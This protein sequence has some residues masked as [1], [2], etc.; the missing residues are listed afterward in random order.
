MGE[1]PAEWCSICTGSTAITAALNRVLEGMVRQ[2]PEQW[3]WLHNRWK[4]AFDETH[5]HHLWSDETEFSIAR[6][7]WK[8]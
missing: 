3:L 8:A 1:L 5:R 2:H 4:S 6:E 7:R